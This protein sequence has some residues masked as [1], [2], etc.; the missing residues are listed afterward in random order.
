MFLARPSRVLQTGGG[1][2]SASR[3]R[4]TYTQ[5]IAP[6]TAKGNQVSNHF[7]LSL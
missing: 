2:G 5:R 4:A 6:D 7:F 1:I 3:D